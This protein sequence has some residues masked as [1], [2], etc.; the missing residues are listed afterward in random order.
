[1]G[2][3]KEVGSHEAERS[4]LQEVGSMQSADVDVLEH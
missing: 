3:V 4:S 1:M 2:G